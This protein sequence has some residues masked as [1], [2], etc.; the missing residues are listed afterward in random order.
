MSPEKIQE[1]V[2]KKKEK[3]ERR[4]YIK[5][6]LLFKLSFQVVHIDF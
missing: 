5:P 3:K 2:K 1:N 6:E 4:Y